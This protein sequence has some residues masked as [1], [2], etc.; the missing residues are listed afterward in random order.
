MA[1]QPL[2]RIDKDSELTWAMEWVSTLLCHENITITPD[3]KDRLWSALVNLSKTPVRERTLTGLSALLQGNSLKQAL[4]PY[5]LN[6]PHGHLLDADH[7]GFELGSMMC[8][9]MEQL[10]H[11]RSVTLPVLT[12]LFHRLESNFDGKPTL[13]ILDEAWVFLDDPTFAGRI[14]E[15]L[16]VLR[17]KNVSVIFA[18]QSLSDIAESTIAPAIIESCPSRLFLPNPRALEPQ[19]QKIYQNFGLNERQ[20]EIIANATPKRDYYF[21]CRQGNR[22]FD[23]ALGPVALAFTAAITSGRS[24]PPNGSHFAVRYLQERNL[25]WAA[26][27][28]QQFSNRKDG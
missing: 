2:A 4:I 27:L 24:N 15:W 18:T 8:F 21:S 11:N 14:R 20:I 5:T 10:M 7:D 16:K 23:L 19:Q 3:V 28:V 25:S 12:Y 6:G 22:L 9:E 26:E 17:K 1:F 13:L